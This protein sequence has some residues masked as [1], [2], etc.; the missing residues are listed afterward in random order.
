MIKF[1][2]YKKG[3]IMIAVI[4][5]CYNE[6]KNIETV[7]LEL[8]NLNKTLE[9]FVVND[10]STDNSLEVLK[11]IENIKILDLPINLGVGGA[12]QLAFKLL[13]W[14]SC[15]IAI[16]ID[17]D[18]QHDPSYLKALIEPILQGQA[19]I[20]IG[21]RYKKNKNYKTPFIR[22]FGQ[23]ILALVANCLTRKNFTDPTSGFRAYNK[24]A[25]KFMAKNYPNFGYPEPEELILASKYKFNVKEVSV[26]MRTRLSGTST[27]TTF[28][29]LVYM[30]KVIVAMF[31]IALRKAK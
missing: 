9:I 6:A 24:E 10:A 7:I 23:K 29:A 14:Q 22:R 12:M 1:N 15:S 16:K 11:S 21:S 2:Y 18:G 4:I 20:T 31:F 27:I 25:I 5:P 28:G 17:G 13:A 19:Q 30:V 8:Q 3:L 26:N